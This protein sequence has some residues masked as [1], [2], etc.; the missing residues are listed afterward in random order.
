MSTETLTRSFN[1]LRA[2]V[3]RYTPPMSDFP[4]M[5]NL[6]GRRCVV[7]GGGPVAARRAA[8]LQEAGAAVTVVAPD[9]YEGVQRPGVEVRRRAYETGDLEG[10]FLVVIATDDGAVNERVARDARAAGLLVNRADDPG[11]SDFTVP[12][13]ARHGA[14]TLA[15]HT[16]GVS[17][18]A[19]AAIRRELSRALD[20]DWA[21]LLEVAGPYRGQ[22]QARYADAPARRRDR[23]RRLTDAEA[24]GIL[25]RQ[26]PEALRHHCERL[27]AP[28]T[29]PPS[30]APP[31][32][33]DSPKPPELPE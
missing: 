8:A 29:P 1:A 26:G 10:A 17:A 23:L 21:R 11:K 14:I 5:L 32:P 7:V 2:G 27:L 12:A 16:G 4:V 9:V 13:H 15:V 24:M 30:P 28:G 22:I 6:R 31:E 33:P 18:S 3:G 25:K 19:A 20:A